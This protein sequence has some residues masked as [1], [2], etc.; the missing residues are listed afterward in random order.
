MANG[1]IFPTV[2]AVAL[3]TTLAFPLQAEIEEV[4]VTARKT[5]ESISDSPVSV[6]VLGED[7]FAEGA[8]NT[9]EEL[10]RFVPGLEL[11]P[12]NTTRATG[13]KMRGIST[14]SFSDGFE[15]SVATVVD[16]VVMGREAQGFFDLY[17][18][19]SVEIL[20]G[21]QGTLFGKNASA[22]V[23]NVKTLSP[24]FETSGGF[25][26]SYGSYDEIL[27]RGTVTG[28]LAADKL[29]YRLSG[30]FNT[31]DGKIENAL[32]GEDDINDKDTWSLRGKLLFTPTDRFQ[33]TLITDYV[34]EDNKCCLP[35][36]RVIGPQTPAVLFALNSPVLQLSDALTALGIDGGE[37]NREVAV[38]D[39]RILQ[40]SEAYGVSLQMDFASDFGDITSITAWRKWEIDEFNEG[41]GL[42][43][44]DVNNRNGTRSDSTQFSQEI[45]LS[46]QIG[47]DIDFVSGLYYFR[48]ELDAFGRV[49][50]E[51]AL[52]IP[53]FF[54][55]ST[56]VDRS[57]ENESAAVFGE[58]TFHMNDAFSV[59]V[60][61]RYT[62]E[63]VDAQYARVA[64][65]IIPFLPFASNFGPDLRGDQ[66]VD[67]TDLSGRVIA[68]YYFNDDAMTYLTWSRGYKGPGIDVAETAN[69]GFLEEP[70]GL[71]VL[72][73]EVPTLYELGAKFRLLDDTL[74][75]N[76][77]VFYQS[78]EDLQAIATD[79]FGIG[80][81]L[82]IDEVLSTGV[83][84]DLIWVPGSI[85][86][87]TLTAG[88]G[89]LDT[90]IEEFCDR[91]D[92][93]DKRFRDVPRWTYSLTGD[94]QFTVSGG[95]NGFV[96]AEF[97]G[98]SRK[99]TNLDDDPTADVDGYSLVNL[100]LGLASTDNRYR[101][102]LI[103]QNVLDE[104]YPH[105]VFGSSY[106]ALDGTT[107]SQ[108]LG[109]PATYAVQFAVNF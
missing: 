36:Y 82:S 105:F 18:I 62:R 78:V 109:D 107:R 101:L 90:N 68:R 77:A 55:V 37:D 26:V 66:N 56:A 70:G 1:R 96:R 50:V 108:F 76:T 3:L 85:D 33:A 39:E 28:P 88:I 74:V 104:D 100:R 11:T 94:Y 57:V 73:P 51:F 60:G 47:D 4:V 38:L 20:K 44:S 61:A 59:I 79:Q 58:F 21:P 80:R 92:L 64:S 95:W 65:P 53:P 35:T 17:S 67:D 46:G 45:R 91:P 52:P 54:N 24:E 16:G 2:L 83:E 86:G 15:S 12:I 22:G 93:E 6:S 103:A 43:N 5:E 41:D 10:V 25:D 48:Q 72:D 87:L 23:I 30:S 75:L 89:Y 84:A 19:E 63:D 40:E 106:A 99:N 8:I 7:F 32:P 42:S 81:N 13:P 102:T 34:E 69:A 98:Q 31:H 97:V 49:D 71:P 27:A 14:F 9:V 29:A